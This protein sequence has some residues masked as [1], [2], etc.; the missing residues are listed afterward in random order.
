MKSKTIAIALALFLGGFGFHKFY[1]GR[2]VAGALY[3]VFCWTF[4]P[5]LLGILDALVYLMMP[6]DRFDRR[7]S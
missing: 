6:R 5:A 4:I 1:L 3:L 2:N 7:Y